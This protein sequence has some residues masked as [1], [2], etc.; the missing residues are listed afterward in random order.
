MSPSGV[1]WFLPLVVRR[2]HPARGTTHGLAPRGAIF[3]FRLLS[4]MSRT[5]SGRFQRILL[6]ESVKGLREEP[7]ATPNAGHARIGRAF[8]KEGDASSRKFEIRLEKDLLDEAQKL[9]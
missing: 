3:T 6:L 9:S 2:L 1:D 4:F 7:A 8:E 5:S